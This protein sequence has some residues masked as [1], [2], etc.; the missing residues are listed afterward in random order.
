MLEIP[1]GDCSCGDV[2]ALDVF[3]SNNRRFFCANTVVNEYI[4]LRLK[5][6]GTE[7]V[8]IFDAIT[9]GRVKKSERA[10]C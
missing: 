5:R 4:R 1:V 9:S 6:S 2:L 7:R 3:D 8:R 10:R